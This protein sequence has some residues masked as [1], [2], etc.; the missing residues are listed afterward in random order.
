MEQTKLAYATVTRDDFLLFEARPGLAL[1]LL[2]DAPRFTCVAVSHDLLR[3]LN[4]KKET[5]VGRGF[6]EI[7]PETPAAHFPDLREALAKAV[8]SGE[9][10]ELPPL[11]FD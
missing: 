11:R 4:E 6:W 1:A 10:L 3:A 2:P 7:F 8:Q 9:P 5:L